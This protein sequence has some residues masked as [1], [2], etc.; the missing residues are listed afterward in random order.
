MV[1]R[2]QLLRSALAGAAVSVGLWGLDLRSLQFLEVAGVSD[3]AAQAQLVAV[4]R[5]A[6]LGLEGKLLGIHVVAG[7]L[8]GGLLSLALDAWPRTARLRLRPLGAALYVL[9]LFSLALGGMMAH[10]PQLY[11]DRWWLAGGG[12]AALQRLVTHGL[13]PRPFDVL[14][15]ALLLPIAAAALAHPLR[16]ALRSRRRL[17]LAGLGIALLGLA[18]LPLSARASRPDPR[19]SLLILAS[20]SLRADRLEDPG[21]MPASAARLG[22]GT[23]F[24]HA[25]APIA[26][27]FQSW[28]SLFTGLEPRHHGI[29]TM[30]PATGLRQDI[31]PSFVSELR[32]RGYQTFVVSDFA[33]DI[34]PRLPIPFDATDAPRFTADDL[35]RSTTLGVHGWTLP[36]LRLPPFRRWLPEWRNLASL[37]DPEWLADR[38]F[39]QIDRAGDRPFAGLVFFSTSHFPYVAPWPDYLRGAGD[40][41]GPFLYHAPPVVAGRALDPADVAQVRAR[42]D[43]ALVAIDRAMDRLLDRLQGLRSAGRLV[44]VV[45]GD[46]G[47]ELYEDAGIAG[48]GDRITAP[49]SQSVPLFLA[50]PGVTAG[51]KVD[52]QVRTTD[53]AATVLGLLL[54]AQAGRPYGDGFSLL[55]P[56]A[57]RP[58]CL[59]S[60]IWFWPDL[61]AGL[62]G[63]RLEYRGIAD[64]VALDPSSREIVLRA[65]VE[66]EVE[67]AKQRGLVLGARLLVEQLTPQGR[68]AWTL[69]LPG[70]RPQYEDV[71]LA[72]LFEQRCVGGDPR[73]R[74]VLGGIVYH[75]A[76]A[77]S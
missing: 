22:E 3:A 74:R 12:R 34:F 28:A 77:G 60:G 5:P 75:P 11:A 14:F 21:V 63:Q 16:W 58:L 65:D 9:T 73:L 51:L 20:D 40:Y 2:G 30:F 33:G 49:T 76:R 25:F 64:L 45:T 62:R 53:L 69:Q 1:A 57:P 7:L 29:R 72:A 59:E 66:E 32:D 39:E 56:A 71:D 52:V 54:P 10:Y 70:V 41:R 18:R 36:L 50:G 44:V 26:R 17:A 46:H 61:P 47:E 68:K 4:A 24:R 42:Y 43:G 6:I 8:L 67:S 37:S 15:L 55:A 13:G 23:L 27:T 38:T 35:A 48:H 31:G 19:P